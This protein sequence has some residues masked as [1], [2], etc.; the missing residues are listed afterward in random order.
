MQPKSKS[1]KQQNNQTKPKPNQNKP[2]QTFKQAQT[3]SP[4]NPLKPNKAKRNQAS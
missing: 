3:P 1:I 4:N 2:K